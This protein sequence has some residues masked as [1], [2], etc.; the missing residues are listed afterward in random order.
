MALKHMKTT[1]GENNVKNRHDYMQPQKFV[2]NFLLIRL[3]HIRLEENNNSV[4][5]K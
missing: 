4:E 2:K 5:K 3:N 1:A